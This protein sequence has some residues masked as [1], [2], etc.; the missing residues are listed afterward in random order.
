MWLTKN[1]KIN[2]APENSFKEFL[3]PDSIKKFLHVTHKNT[4]SNIAP[5]N[6]LSKQEQEMESKNNPLK[7][8][9]A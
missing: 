9:Q 4:K 7:G 3:E 8:G 6:S 5:E 2:I 1:T